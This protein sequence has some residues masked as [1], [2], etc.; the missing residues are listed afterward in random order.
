MDSSLHL[1]PGR[2]KAAH[3]SWGVLVEGRSRMGKRREQI[4]SDLR[5]A[6][7]CVYVSCVASIYA[8]VCCSVSCVPITSDNYYY[9]FTFVY[10][11]KWATCWSCHTNCVRTTGWELSLVGY[12]LYTDSVYFPV[13]YMVMSYASKTSL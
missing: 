11:H 12:A 13:A 7:A 6:C 10:G 1:V 8:R 3:C 5:P 9:S 2:L 4:H